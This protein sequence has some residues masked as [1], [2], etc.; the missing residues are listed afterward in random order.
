MRFGLYLVSTKEV[1]K[2]FLSKI[3]FNK[4]IFQNFPSWTQST[5][6]KLLLPID[7]FEVSLNWGML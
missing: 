3:F 2:Y 5:K 6:L 7:N 1:L 4:T